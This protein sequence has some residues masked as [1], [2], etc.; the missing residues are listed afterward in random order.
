MEQLI[1]N[2]DNTGDDSQ[3]EIHINKGIKKGKKQ[4]AP[5]FYVTDRYK[6]DSDK[7]LEDILYSEEFIEALYDI[8]ITYTD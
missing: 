3:K 4:K 5:D 2:K 1:K 6:E 7:T 8:V